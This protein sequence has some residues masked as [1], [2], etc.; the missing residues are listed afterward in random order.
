MGSAASGKGSVQTVVQTV[1]QSALRLTTARY[2]RRQVG[3]GRG[4]DPDITV[5]QTVDPITITGR[6][7]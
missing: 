1:P 5:P 7:A 6:G 2:Y 3:S 4:I